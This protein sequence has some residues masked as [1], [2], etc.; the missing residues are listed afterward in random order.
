MPVVISYRL[1]PVGNMKALNGTVSCAGWRDRL[2]FVW[3]NRWTYSILRGI[4]PFTYEDYEPSLS[5][6]SVASL[7][8]YS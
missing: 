6:V 3:Q 7:Q 2:F 4:M 8:C 1:R 5:R